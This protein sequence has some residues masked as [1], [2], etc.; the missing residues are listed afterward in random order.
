MLLVVN[1][2]TNN[3][4]EQ[5][6]PERQIDVIGGELE[7]LSEKAH[8][9]GALDGTIHAYDRDSYV[10]TYGSEVVEL[11]EA[12]AV[13]DYYDFLSQAHEIAATDTTPE[14]EEVRRL[15]QSYA[16]DLRFLSTKDFESAC[17]GLARSQA[18]FLQENPQRSVLFF[19]HPNNLEK[20]QGFVA[21]RIQQEMDKDFAGRSEVV[22]P[23]DFGGLARILEGK[24]PADVKLVLADDWTVSGNHLRNDT[25][26]L[27]QRLRHEGLSEEWVKR[28]EINLLVARKDQ[29][30]D[31]FKQVSETEETLEMEEP[32]PVK[33]YFETPS[34]NGV[35]SDDPV[36]TGSH[37]SVDYG[38]EMVMGRLQ[39]YISQ[40]DRMKHI[41][42]PYLASIKRS[43]REY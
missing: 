36:P 2:E 31:G 43:Y 18:E 4:L 27:V 3:N 26:R 42:L 11:S 6:R 14:G 39:Q 29:I 32:I 10:S 5:Y 28:I 7:P 41:R 23:R 24:D 9:P 22:S 19:V 37:S 13:H 17:T 20:S 16:E 30:D 1:H 8:Q 21:G 40:H 38:F 35:F 15:A 12:D 34:I 33:A 25:A